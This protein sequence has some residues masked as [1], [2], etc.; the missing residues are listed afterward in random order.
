MKEN[1]A[2][3]KDM[4]AKHGCHTNRRMINEMSIEKVNERTESCQEKTV[5]VKDVVIDAWPFGYE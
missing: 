2:D 3:R 1:E 5:S 4:M